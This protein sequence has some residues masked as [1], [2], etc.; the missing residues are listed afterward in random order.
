MAKQEKTKKPEKSQDDLRDALEK[1]LFSLKPAVEEELKKYEDALSNDVFEDQEGEPEGSGEKRKDE[2]Q[3]RI[4]S[5]IDRAEGMKGKL[6]SKE[7][8]PQSAP[9]ISATY[10][11]T[12]PQTHKSEKPE[13][14][15]LNI[16]EKLQDFLSFYQKTNIDLPPDFEQTIQDIWE[17]NSDQ[18]Q[19]AIE[20][21]GFDD[22]LIIPATPDIGD[23]SEKMKMQ[24]GYY[25]YINSSGN[26]GTL[27]GI[28]LESDFSQNVD[29][30]RIV[31][32]HKTQNLKDRPELKQTLN[33]KGQ[34]VVLNQT[35][36]LE[37]Y[38]VFQRKY[39]EETGNHLDEDGWTWLAT[40]SG[41]RL[42]HSY[43]S[44]SY[45]EFNV[46]AGDLDSRNDHLGARPS[47]SFF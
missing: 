38:L 26:V 42:V 3:S 34:Y 6:D 24:N 4:D 1:R 23:L 47:R 44:P 9:E 7:P 25:D 40:K 17:K 10:T 20:Q 27:A 43:W 37:D 14:I 36:T 45:G 18:I 2:M 28:P 32:V 19:Q 46:D 21:N 39:F 16:E 11:Y 5:M 29:Q 31:L 41:T 22:I 8:L 12:D 35:L 13:T 30:P 15:T 33:V